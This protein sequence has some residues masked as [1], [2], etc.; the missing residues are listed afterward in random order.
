M[1]Q[2]QGDEVEPVELEQMK[3]LQERE[4]YKQDWVAKNAS[5]INHLQALSFFNDFFSEQEEQEQR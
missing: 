3:I 4:G 2:K 5:K 1:K